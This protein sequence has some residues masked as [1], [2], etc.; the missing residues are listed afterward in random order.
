MLVDFIVEGFAEGNDV[1]V[2][3]I[4]LMLHLWIAEPHVHGI[5][6]M[7][8]RAVN[9]PASA[10]LLFRTE[11]NCGSKNSLESFDDASIVPAIF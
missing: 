9:H 6:K 3:G 11:E 10:G 7:K 5:K 8:T 1:R 2:V 4:W